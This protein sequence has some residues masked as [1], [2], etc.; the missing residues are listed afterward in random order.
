M[1]VL[2]TDPGVHQWNIQVKEMPKALYVY[3]PLNNQYGRV[4]ELK[5]N[6]T[7]T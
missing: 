2:R 6:S 1:L 5:M 4:K 7:Y 3:P